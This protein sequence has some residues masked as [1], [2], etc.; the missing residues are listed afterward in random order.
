MYEF[1][2]SKGGS[3]SAEHG[4]GLMKPDKIQYSKGAAAVELMRTLKKTM[5]PNNILNPYKTVVV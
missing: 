3:V 5:D 4:L 2:A 1:V